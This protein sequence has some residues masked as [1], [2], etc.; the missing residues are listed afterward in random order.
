M[1][2]TCEPYCYY[3]SYNFVLANNTTYVSH[4]KSTLLNNVKCN[5]NEAHKWAHAEGKSYTCTQ[6]FI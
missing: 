5:D 6:Q 2:Y 3:Y 4:I 1:T